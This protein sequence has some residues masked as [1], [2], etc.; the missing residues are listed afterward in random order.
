M[1]TLRPK[2]FTPG[3]LD[4]VGVKILDKKGIKLECIK[5]GQVWWPMLQPGGGR[6]PRNYWKCPNGCLGKK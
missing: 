4:R 5:C 6:L 1:E 2:R 3:E